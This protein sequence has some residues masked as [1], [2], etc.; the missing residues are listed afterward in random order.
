MLQCDVLVSTL[1]FDA[2]AGLMT[3]QSPSYDDVVTITGKTL[4]SQPQLETL[5]TLT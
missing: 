5:R 3:G 2:D 4:E 1:F